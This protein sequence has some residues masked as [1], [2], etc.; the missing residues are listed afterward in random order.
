MQAG[1]VGIKPVIEKASLEGRKLLI[2][3]KDKRE[4]SIPKQYFPFLKGNPG[5]IFISDFDTLIF[6]N[7]DEV[8]HIS[9][10]LGRFEDYKYKG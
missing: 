9:E 1:I 6:E 7:A 2:K 10:I 5:K 8:I 3:L 4:I